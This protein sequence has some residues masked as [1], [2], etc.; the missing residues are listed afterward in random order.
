MPVVSDLK[1]SMNTWVLAVLVLALVSAE[2]TAERS[3][4]GGPLVENFEKFIKDLLVPKVD[5]WHVGMNKC[6]D[7][8]VD[9]MDLQDRFELTVDVPGISKKDIKV[10]AHDSKIIIEAERLEE[11]ERRETP[12]VIKERMRGHMTRAISLPSKI[13]PDRIKARFQHGTLIVDAPKAPESE[14]QQIEIN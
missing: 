4:A 14:I 7:L 10:R 6:H 9:F 1:T 13:L 3:K 11:L 2:T 5:V 12:F 8:I